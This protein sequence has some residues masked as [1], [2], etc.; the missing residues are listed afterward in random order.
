MRSVYRVLVVIGLAIMFRGGTCVYGQGGATGAISGS[1][2]D[3][4]GGSVAGAD[5]QIIDV[6]TEVVVRR[7]P[8]GS[9]GSFVVALLPREFTPRW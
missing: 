3:T 5:V 4:S 1:V 8:T 6:R 7:V 2:V 9:D